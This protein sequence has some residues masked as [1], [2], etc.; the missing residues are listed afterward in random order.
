MVFSS[1]WFDFYMFKKALKV[2][3][4]IDVYWNSGFI[5]YQYNPSI[6]GFYFFPNDDLA[7]IYPIANLF[8]NF[9][10]KRATIFLKFEYFNAYFDPIVFYSTVN[11][12]HYPEFY[13]RYGVR[14]WFKN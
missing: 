12:Y 7:G 14:W 11:H 3:S 4:G 10:V 2:H 5:R 6:L 1:F 13:M 9:K 8:F